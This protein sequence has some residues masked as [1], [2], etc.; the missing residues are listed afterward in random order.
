MNEQMKYNQRNSQNSFR[1][2]MEKTVERIHILIVG[3]QGLKCVCK[4]KHFVDRSHVR[5]LF[6]KWIYVSLS[7][8][9]FFP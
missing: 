5:T 3:L 2:N 7:H 1:G 6:I 8:K 4:V 9:P